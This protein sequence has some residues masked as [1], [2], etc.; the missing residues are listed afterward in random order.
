MK[1]NNET[2]EQLLSLLSKGN[3]H[4]YGKT[5]NYEHDYKKMIM[6]VSQ[7]NVVLIY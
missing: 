2:D 7:W 5:N 3:K 6:Q 1:Y 4:N